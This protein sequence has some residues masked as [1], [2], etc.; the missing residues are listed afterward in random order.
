M[1]SSNDASGKFFK[2]MAGQLY[3]SIALGRSSPEH[4]RILLL[5]NNPD[6][7]TGTIPEDIWA[8]GG[9]YPFITSPV[10]LEIVSSSANDTA[11]GTGARTIAIQGLDTNYNEITQVVT[12]NGV[13]PVAIGTSLVAVN[14]AVVLSAGTTESNEGLITIRDLGGGTTRSILP[15]NGSQTRKAIYTVPAGYTLHITHFLTALNRTAGTATNYATVGLG[16]R[17]FA[18]VK[19]IPFEYGVSSINPA[20]FEVNTGA[21]ILE[22][23]ILFARCIDVSASNTNITVALTGVLSKNE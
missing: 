14:A 21:V 22:K 11:A 12:M 4:R 19:R 18:G 1:I 23:E 20:I 15:I 6:V 8:N 7:D 9:L 17:S 5:G 2:E 16:V 13:V 10:F 3:H